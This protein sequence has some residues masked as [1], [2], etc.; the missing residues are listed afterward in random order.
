M[1]DS[2]LQNDG[3]RQVRAVHDYWFERTAAKD[4]EG[5]MRHIAD[6]IVSYEH[7]APLQ[8]VGRDQVRE[9]CRNGLESAEGTV[10]WGVPDMRVLVR[11]DLAVVWGLNRMTAQEPDGATSTSWSRGTRVLQR[12]DGEWTMVHQHVSY[13]YDAGTGDAKTDL[14]P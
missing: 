6:D 13:P 9:V 7:D 10:S 2:D 4:L 3:E 8:Y 14:S 5:L 12:R 11:D 1:S